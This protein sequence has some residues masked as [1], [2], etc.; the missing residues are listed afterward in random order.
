MYKCKYCGKECKNKNSLSNHERLCKLNPN[1][2][3]SP[4]VKYNKEKGKPWNKGLTKEIDERVK[5]NGESISNS[6]KNGSTIAWCQGLT[7]E[8]DERIRLASDKISSTISEKI[9]ND[10]WHNSFGKS[11]IVSYNDIDFHG[12]W[13]VEFAKYL[14]NLQI[15]WVR[16]TDKF[17]Y[18]FDNKVRYYTPDFYIPNIDLYIEIKGYPTEKDFTKWDSFPSDKKLNIYFGDELFELGIIESYRNVYNNVLPKYRIK[19]KL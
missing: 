1:R 19:Y 14:D 15:D 16:N 11:K 10:A 8:T 4:F 13:E 12:R 2:Q 17:E 18:I 7:K 3:E 9:K 5:R 6:Y